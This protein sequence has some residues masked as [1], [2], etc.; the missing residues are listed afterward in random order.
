MLQLTVLMAVFFFFS[1]Y[2]CGIFWTTNSLFC[3]QMPAGA[4]SMFGPGTK[5][6]LSEG[7]KKR[8]L[9]TSEESEKSEEVWIVRCITPESW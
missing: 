8:Q 3:H 6:L 7:L 5:S 2:L 9:S 4:I 1:V